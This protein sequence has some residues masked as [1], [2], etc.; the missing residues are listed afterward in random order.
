[1]YPVSV[2]IGVGVN[3]AFALLPLVVALIQGRVRYPGDMLCAAIFYI[4]VFSSRRFIS[5]ISSH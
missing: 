5:S 3:Y 4:L 1:M 2:G